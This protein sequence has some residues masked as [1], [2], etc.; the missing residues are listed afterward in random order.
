MDVTSRHDV[1][2]VREDILDTVGC[3]DILI[4]NAGVMPVTPILMPDPD[5]IID[6]INVNLLAHFWVWNIKNN[7]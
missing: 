7:K 6:V 1:Q 3:V 5:T 4:N 2:R